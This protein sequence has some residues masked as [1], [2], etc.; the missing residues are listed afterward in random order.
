[1]TETELA[2]YADLWGQRSDTPAELLGA[3]MAFFLNYCD[4]GKVAIYDLPKWLDAIR[5]LSGWREEIT[6]NPRLPTIRLKDAYGKEWKIIH[7]NS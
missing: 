2:E 6:F 5:P 3:A 4:E 1:M 7:G